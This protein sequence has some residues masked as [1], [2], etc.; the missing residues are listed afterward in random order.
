MARALREYEAE[1]EMHATA[2]SEA[3]LAHGRKVSELRSELAAERENS[4]RLQE[5]L[6][7]ADSKAAEA[8]GSPL[9]VL[10]QPPPWSGWVAAAVMLLAMLV[11]SWTSPAPAITSD[12]EAM[13]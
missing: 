7:A 4:A 6:R 11:R 2:L 13:R 12:D 10:S 9:G 3:E 1:R 8:R 5:K